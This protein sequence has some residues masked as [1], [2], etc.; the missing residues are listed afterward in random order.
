MAGDSS[1]DSR[2]TVVRGN[3]PSLLQC[4]GKPVAP[5]VRRNKPS[6]VEMHWQASG[7]QREA[8]L[9]RSQKQAME[10]SLHWREGSVTVRQTHLHL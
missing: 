8:I 1:V 10:G 4:T 7:T 6:F 2:C 9:G 3:K 5:V